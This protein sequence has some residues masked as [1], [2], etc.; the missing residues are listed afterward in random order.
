MTEEKNLR[1]HLLYELKQAGFPSAVVRL[2]TKDKPKWVA[3][4]RRF[5]GDEPMLITQNMWENEGTR[6]N[7]IKTMQHEHY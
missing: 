5:K 7:I 4:I 6:A 1:G 2:Q 3:Y